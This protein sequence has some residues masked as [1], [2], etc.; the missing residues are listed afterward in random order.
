MPDGYAPDR[1]SARQRTQVD[2]AVSKLKSALGELADVRGPKEAEAPILAP[3]VRW[4]LSQWLNE[5]R[6]KKELEAVG[7][8]P[9]TTAILKGPPG[10]GKTT[11]AHHLAGRLGLPMVVAGPETI[12]SKYLSDSARNAAKLFDAMRESG[13]PCLLFLDELDA[14]GSSREGSGGSACDRELLS[15][16][17]VLMRKIEEFDGLCISATNRPEVIDPAL[18]RRFQIQLSVDLPE[19]EQRFAIIKRYSKPYEMADEDIG[20]L[21]GLTDNASPALLK[22]LM[23][24]MKRALIVYPKMKIPIDDPKG[25]FLSVIKSIDPPPGLKRPPLWDGDTKLAAFDAF[26]SW[27]PVVKT[28]A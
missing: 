28:D 8:R 18:W 22:G 7:C 10:T 23:E 3:S 2:I 12:V 25:V 20:L 5:L 14:L 16:L 19:Y 4:A 11:L 17:T 21:T 13:M 24:G 1:G 6:A 15:M 26:T 9:R 27:P